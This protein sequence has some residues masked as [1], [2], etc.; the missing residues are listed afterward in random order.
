MRKIIPNINPAA[1]GIQFIIP[2][3][4]AR[5]TDGK[6]SDHILA[7]IITPAAKPIINFCTF[8]FKFFFKNK[9][10]QLPKL[11]PIHGINIPI[12]L[13]NVLFNLSSSSHYIVCNL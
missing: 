1:A 10:K 12:I 6:I 5:S 11:V 7:A 2:C 13:Y 4:S 8:S 9:T 3:S